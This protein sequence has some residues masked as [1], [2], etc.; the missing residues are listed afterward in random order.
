[1]YIF[2]FLYVEIPDSFEYLFL[3]II[4]ILKYMA[5]MERKMSHENLLRSNLRQ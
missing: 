1:M 2:M 5:K 4:S 3:Y